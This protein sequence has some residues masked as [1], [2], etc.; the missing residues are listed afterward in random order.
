M[1]VPA[2]GYSTAGEPFG[3]CLYSGYNSTAGSLF[4][5]VFSCYVFTQGSSTLS[6]NSSPNPT[7]I[8]CTPSMPIISFGFVSRRR[9]SDLVR[10]SV[11]CRPVSTNSM[12]ICP[13]STQ[14]LRKWNFTSMCLLRSC[15]TRFFARTMAGY[16][17]TIS[18]SR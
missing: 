14:S 9:P 10:T 2:C 8:P 4:G 17:S 11:S 7:V 16:L 15:R 13:P 18:A 6:N 3:A 1:Y 5:V 12:T